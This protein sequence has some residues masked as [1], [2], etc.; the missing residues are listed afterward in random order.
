[1][2]L[3]FVNLI[4]F[5]VHRGG[6]VLNK[7]DYVDKR[8]IKTKNAIKSTLLSFLQLKSYEEI[9]IADIARTSK[10]SRV[11]FYN[12]YKSKEILID[13]VINDVMEDLII[14][15][16][17][18]YYERSSFRLIDITPPTIKIFEHVYKHASYYHAMV[19]SHILFKFQNRLI[20]VIKKIE[21]HDNYL[22][23]P[24]INREIYADYI[25]SAISGLIIE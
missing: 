11:T 3:I 25:A 12:H 16:R 17:K 1:M 7:E 5:I 20:E 15:Y 23:N 18:P 24:K 2:L 6:Q 19:N 21:L 8:I 9:T 4:Y 22:M 10:I 14:S 13:E